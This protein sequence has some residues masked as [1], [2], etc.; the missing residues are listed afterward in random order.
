ML[1]FDEFYSGD[2]DFVSFKE[3]FVF[4][5]EGTHK[6]WD[7]FKL[8]PGRPG[9]GAEEAVYL[10]DVGGAQLE[11]IPCVDAYGV[12]KPA[13]DKFAPGDVQAGRPYVVLQERNAV[14]GL[15]ELAAFYVRLQ[16]G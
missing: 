9:D 15:L 14:Y 5:D 3:R 7:Y 10:A 12:Q 8:C 2:V 1:V 6:V 16:G 4:R 11:A 13:A